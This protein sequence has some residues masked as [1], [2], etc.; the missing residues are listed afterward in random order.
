MISLRSAAPL[1]QIFTKDSLCFKQHSK[2]SVNRQFALSV[3]RCFRFFFL[4]FGGSRF[5]GIQRDHFDV[6][7][8][9]VI[10]GFAAGN[11]HSGTNQSAKNNVAKGHPGYGFAQP[12]CFGSISFQFVANHLSFAT[13]L[14]H[15]GGWRGAAGNVVDADDG[16]LGFGAEGYGLAV[17]FCDCRAAPPTRNRPTGLRRQ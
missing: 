3:V 14:Y 16:A 7:A 12:K 17:I 8:V 15:D 5:R 9:F 4:F 6:N 10:G 1:N 2:V 11:I 13:S